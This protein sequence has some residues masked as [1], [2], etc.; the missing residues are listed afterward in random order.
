MRTD[1]YEYLG[2]ARGHPGGLLKNFDGGRSTTSRRPSSCGHSGRCSTGRAPTCTLSA[3]QIP[4]RAPGPQRGAAARARR[5]RH[6]GRS[7]HACIRIIGNRRRRQGGP[8][9]TRCGCARVRRNWQTFLQRLEAARPVHGRERRDVL[10]ERAGR[11]AGQPPPP[12]G[13]YCAPRRRR[14]GRDPGAADGRGERVHRSD[15]PARRVAERGLDACADRSPINAFDNLSAAYE[16]Y[17]NAL[18]RGGSI[19]L[20]ARARSRDGSAA[21]PRHAHHHACAAWR[22]RAT[23]A[24]TVTNGRTR[25]SRKRRSTSSTARRSACSTSRRRRRAAASETLQLRRSIRH[26]GSA[27]REPPAGRRDAARLHQ[28]PEGRPVGSRAPS[29]PGVKAGCQTSGGPMR[30]HLCGGCIAVMCAGG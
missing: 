11:R 13:G 25:R 24:G 1:R 19:Y 3:K 21:L 30:P 28:P 4:A 12:A 8:R 29:G 23:R 2:G 18:A 5:A 7:R 9:P 22:M 20:P 14:D 6:A 15:D 10:R 26:V 16:A 17:E 27:D